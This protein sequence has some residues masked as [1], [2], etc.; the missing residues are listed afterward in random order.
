MS[1]SVLVD[2]VPEDFIYRSPAQC[3]SVIRDVCWITFRD[4]RL[5]IHF[6]QYLRRTQNFKCKKQLNVSQMIKVPVY[7]MFYP[8]TPLVFHLSLTRQSL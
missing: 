1:Y 2:D 4:I 7:L 6:L 5:S 3:E 8:N